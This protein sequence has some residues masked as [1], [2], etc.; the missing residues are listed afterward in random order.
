MDQRALAKVGQKGQQDWKVSE[1]VGSCDVKP[2]NVGPEDAAFGFAQS[3]NNNPWRIAQTASMRSAAEANGVELIVTDA[4]SSTPKQ[5]SDIQ[6]MV[7]QVST[8]SSSHR[9]RRRVW[10]RLSN[11]AQTYL[12]RKRT[13]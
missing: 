4:R 8:C 12:T 3:E 13:S 2:P 7:A 5:V 1:G 11:P 10:R 9:A 6:D